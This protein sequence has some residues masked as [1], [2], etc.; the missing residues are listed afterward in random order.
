MYAFVDCLA[1]GDS[2]VVFVLSSLLSDPP[3]LFWIAS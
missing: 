3:K 1:A 2:V